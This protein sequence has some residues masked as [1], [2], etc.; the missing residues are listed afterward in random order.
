M[1]QHQSDSGSSDDSMD[2][3]PLMKSSMGSRRHHHRRSSIEEPP[4]VLSDVIHLKEELN[5]L[6]EEMSPKYQENIKNMKQ[7]VQGFE[8]DYR[9]AVQAF[10]GGA[11]TAGVGAGTLIAGLVLSIFTM[12]SSAIAAGIVAAAASL[13]AAGAIIL[14]IG[15]FKKKQQ[16]K[17]LNKSLE[18]E[19]TELQNKISPVIDV[20]KRIFHRVQ[21]ILRNPT[22]SEH[23]ANEIRERFSYCFEKMHLFQID[24]NSEARTPMSESLHFTG[25]LSKTFA[26][27]S[28]ML[29]LLEE[30][31]EDGDEAHSDRPADTAT[32]KKMEKEFKE[33]SEKF[34]NEMKKGINQLENVLNEIGHIKEKL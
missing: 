14:A 20:L 21:E 8:Q 28:S 5:K 30:I 25:D 22:L 12:G 2:N 17:N 33:K 26:E 19:L 24:D 11:V 27:I 9:S 16:E 31:L 4:D 10:T 13:L 7:L 29:E 32:G 34:I 15:N 3:P 18:N 6:H 23:K 1:H